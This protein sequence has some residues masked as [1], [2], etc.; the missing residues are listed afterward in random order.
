M[1]AGPFLIISFLSWKSSTLTQGSGD[2]SCLC[3]QNGWEESIHVIFN[4]G[5]RGGANRL[6]ADKARMWGKARWFKHNLGNK[7]KL[8]SF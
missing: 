5:D 6:R 8:D 3:G 1:E 4:S 7:R 2:N